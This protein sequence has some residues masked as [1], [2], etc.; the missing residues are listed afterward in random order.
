[1]KKL[2]AS[3][4]VIAALASPAAAADLITKAQQGYASYPSTSCGFYFGA[5][6]M[7]SANAV[8]GAAAGTQVIQGAIGATIGYTCPLGQG[9]WFIDGMF[10]FSNINGGTTPGLSLSGP[11][12]FEQ[13]FGV[14]AP[15]PMILSLIPGLSALQNALPALIPLPT[16]V[17]IVTTNPYAYVGIHEDDTGVA[18]GL[19]SN[20]QYLTSVGF[21]I[22]TKTRLSN[23]VVFDPFAEY[24]L[25]SSEMCLGAPGC[26]RRGPGIR[27][28]AAIEF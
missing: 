10:D 28:G 27:F 11:A 26:V 9:F 15:I 17:V 3:I 18:I 1:M 4:A 2:L 25:P 22:G 14:G 23:G 20:K 21:G 13:R 16:N 8:N 5:N 6:T 19:S 12:Q 24:V 7:G